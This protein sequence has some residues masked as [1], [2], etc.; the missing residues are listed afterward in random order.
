MWEKSVDAA[1][2][3]GP[4][5]CHAALCSASAPNGP[6][7][8]AH[9]TACW[10][11]SR[12]EG[13]G[14]EGWGL[15]GEALG[16]PPVGAPA[17]RT[18]EPLRRLRGTPREGPRRHPCQPLEVVRRP[19]GGVTRKSVEPLEHA[20]P[21]R[22]VCRGRCRPHRGGWSVLWLLVCGSAIPTNTTDG[23]ATGR[24]CR[25]RNGEEDKREPDVT[26]CRGKA[27]GGWVGPWRTH[28]RTVGSQ[29]SW[30]ASRWVAGGGPSPARRPSPTGPPAP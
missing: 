26:E 17:V 10:A 6:F 19:R 16:A 8:P 13:A 1:G 12:A 20:P 30:W 21:V 2:G 23:H 27:G 28:A 24:N 22:R 5:G 14:A 4:I 18:R 15:D 3:T 11:W 7:A 9:S 25:S 29:R